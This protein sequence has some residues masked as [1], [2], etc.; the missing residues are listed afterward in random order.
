MLKFL[1]N[2]KI[3]FDRKSLKI[4]KFLRKDSKRILIFMILYN[5]YDM[6][7]PAHNNNSRIVMDYQVHICIC[8]EYSF[9]LFGYV[10]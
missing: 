3:L 6:L 9:D 7:A 10:I 8:V 2:I 1:A 5:I 4:Y